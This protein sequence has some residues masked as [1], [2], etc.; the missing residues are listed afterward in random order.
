MNTNTNEASRS[1]QKAL[2]K[3]FNYCLRSSK[4]L[5]MVVLFTIVCLHQVWAY[6][7]SAVS[8]SGHT[9]YYEIL[10]GTTNVGVVRP[11]TSSTY[12]NYVSGNVV[13]PATVSY[14]GTTYN[15]TELRSIL[16]ADG[17]NYGSFKSCTGLT[18]VTIPTSVTAIGD[19]AFCMC[20]G[21]TSITIP[22]SVTAIGHGAFYDCSGLT[23]VTI[24][25][26]VTSIGG[27]AFGDCTSLTMLNFN[28]I[29]CNDFAY[30]TFGSCPISTIVIGDSVQRIPAYFAGGKSSLTSVTIP[31]SVTSI[32]EYAFEYCRGLTSV[33]IPNSVTSIGEYAFEN[34]RGLTSVT[35]GNS[36]TSIPSS[37]FE[38]CSSLT[39]L[40]FNAVNCSD[41]SYSN[42]PFIDCPIST[43][44]I[45]DS[46][47]RIPAHFAYGESS[48]TSVT[49]GNL[50][51]S[52]GNHAFR[53]CGGLTSV[54][55]PNS[56][57]IIGSY[58]FS[59][60]S[61]LT[62]LNFNAINCSDFSS[63]TFINCPISTINIGDSVQRIPAHFADGKS[64]LTS[65]T[66]P[67][68]V[69]SIGNDAFK[70]CSGLTSVI[71]PNSVTSIGGYAFHNCTSL[72][73]VTIP[74]S[75]TSI[76][77]GAFY[78]CTGLTSVTIGNSVTSIGEYAFY[79]C[80]S[81]GRIDVKSVTPPTIS[82]NSFRYASF[83]VTVYIP[84]GSLNN[85]SSSSWGTRFP[86]LQESQVF[87]LDVAV[88]NSAMGEASILSNTCTNTAIQAYPYDGY[89]FVGWSDG[90]TDNPRSL[91]VDKD[92]AFVAMFQC[93]TTLTGD[94]SLVACDSYTWIDGITYTSSNNSATYTLINAT[95]CDSV[96]TLNLTINRST[97]GT[98]VI[99][100]CDSYT[101]IDG[102]TYTASNNTATYTL[103]NAAGCDSVVTLNLTINYSNTGVDVIT[104][105]DSYTW[106]DGITYTASNN[107]ATYTL[108]NVDGCDSVVTL[109]LTINNSNTVD[110]ITACDSYTW[111]DGN[112]YTSSNNTATYTLTNAAGCDSVVT[113]N[114][115]INNSNSG[116]DVITA[117][118]SY[119]WID[120]I[121]Y[122]VSNNTATY[123]LTAANGCDSVVTL[124]LTINNSSSY[125]DIV[126]ACDSYTWID[127]NTYVQST[128]TPTYTL[129]AANGCDSIVRLNLT[130]K[131]STTGTDV[132][133]AC[134]S[135]TWIDGVTYT[136]SNNTATYTLTAANG[137]DSVV[138]LNLTINNS[139]TTT[140]VVTVCNSYTWIDGNTY[141]A[142][143]NTATYTL[144]AA[145]GCDSVVTLN[146]TINNSTTG[147]DVVTAC[148]SYTWIDGV[149]YTASN[150]TATY[151]LTN[152]AGCDSVV[153]LD[154]TINYSNTGVDVITACDNYT[155]ID[156]ITYTASNNTAT[157]TLTNA[158]GCDSVVTLNLTIN[159]AV[160]DTIVDTAVNEYVWNGEVYTT[161]GTYQ[162]VGETVNGCDSV[163]TLI[164]T[165]ETVGISEADVLESLSFY[166]NPTS[167]T[168]TFNCTDIQKV[169]VLDAKGRVV[170][171][172]E[173]SYMIDLSKLSKGYY[174]MRITTDNGVTIRK[175]IYN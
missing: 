153:T 127:G 50:V 5:F 71:I 39:T 150:N 118:D 140:D 134:D 31:N 155:W 148:D 108:T 168:I 54:T 110:V 75:V 101:W 120:G 113:L 20:T 163:A 136:S 141:T 43:I 63:N 9:L 158:A 142:S 173:S 67:N 87:S 133:T 109:N 116:V 105:C 162:Y 135:Y 112:T 164:L 34:C 8:S 121:T 3:R 52:I 144:T 47:Q 66:I 169:E 93:N 42:Y 12:N 36:V 79:N 97:T 167:G 65:V 60:C 21:L 49:I 172:Y 137:C 89:I 156:G 154:L 72:T 62:T 51:T 130:I 33:T 81:I 125:T 128:T 143:N 126:T 145:N 15:V 22:N 131:N 160:Y 38:D 100:A 27:S 152:A 85:Y 56:V 17:Y 122:T 29:N 4:R 70:N 88:N 175:V 40:N 170:M 13:I 117:C 78:N 165:I 41:F 95:G 166:P 68:S 7:F 48:L 94:T 151:T 103:T 37:A 102:I 146:L 107:T 106:I 119:T 92:S 76:E 98:D 114:L 90:N 91:V 25:N 2:I 149:T 73:S 147:T 82:S 161:S 24:P 61:G 139:A 96:I 174:T 23:S 10:S 138:T 55:I 64:S 11:G 35:I 86:N 32:G 59:G 26:S 53:Y 157:Y 115:T 74:N 14:N 84:C 69:T 124:N 83:T 104:A 132:V 19:R 18:S 44:V 45:G 99:T 30:Y 46:V 80:T 159:Y 58:A 16:G 6:D 171:I 129:T 111:I 57:S 123:T 28:A 1:S 77:N